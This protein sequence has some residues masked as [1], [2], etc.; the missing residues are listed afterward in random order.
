MS[1]LTRDGSAE[2]VSRVYTLGRERGQQ[3]KVYFPCSADHEQDWRPCPV[4]PYWNTTASKAEVWVEKVAEGGRRFMAAWRK[5]EV[6]AARHGQEK[7]E[8]TR[9]VNLLSHTGVLNYAKPHLL[10]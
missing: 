7:R 3:G 9:L 1:S 8:A 5:K 2:V 10:A 6:G 4:D